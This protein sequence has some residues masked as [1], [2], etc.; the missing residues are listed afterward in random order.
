MNIIIEEMLKKSP[1]EDPVI[2][3]EKMEELKQ[4]G[5]HDFSFIKKIKHLCFL[6]VLGK[7]QLISTK[8]ENYLSCLEKSI[9]MIKKMNV[10]SHEKWEYELP[11][12]SSKT[13]TACGWKE[14]CTKEEAL[15]HYKKG[16]MKLS[17]YHSL[18][19]V[20]EHALCQCGSH[21]LYFHRKSML[22]E[23]ELQCVT[24]H[25]FQSKE[26]TTLTNHEDY[27]D[28]FANVETWEQ[29]IQQE[30]H[31][32]H[33]LDKQITE[34]KEL[35]TKTINLLKRSIEHAIY[36]EGLLEKEDILS[37]IEPYLRFYFETL[38]FFEKQ[39]DG[40]KR[41][42]GLYNISYVQDDENEVAFVNYEFVFEQ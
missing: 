17:P 42:T 39:K 9:E 37:W 38:P 35:H 27:A 26:N 13:C 8:G 14:Q 3:Q 19:Y 36:V 24:C 16:E 10:C 32:Y 28:Y 2:L 31:M 40:Y 20:Q 23:K 25:T 12:S 29:E 7:R 34:Y 18:I 41:V 33:S 21:E 22:T 30:A 4:M 6:N 1:S 11:K 5:F 15:Q